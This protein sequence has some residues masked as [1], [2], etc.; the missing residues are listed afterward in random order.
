MGGWWFV[1]LVLGATFTAN[2]TAIFVIQEKDSGF[3]SIEELVSKIPPNIPFGTYNNSQPASFFKFSPIKQYQEAYEYMST[4]RLL[5]N[6]EKEALSAVLYDNIALIFDSPIIDFISSRRGEY[7]PHCTLK[8]I[9]EGLFFPASYGLGLTKDSPYTDDFSL[10]ILEIVEEG[11]IER[12]SN[13]YFEYQRTCVSEA[14]MTGASASMDTEQITLDSVGGLFILLGIAIILSFIILQVEF[15]Y[16]SLQKRISILQ[17]W[18]S[19]SLKLPWEDKLNQTDEQPFVKE[20]V[21]SLNSE[22][23]EILLHSINTEL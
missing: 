5:Y 13:E 15:A 6:S 1:C 2:L 7:N 12:L 8:D 10:A 23:N 16:H 22:T 21:S 14:A 4:E 17:L 19:L 20:E 9:G 18:N 3:N 11:E